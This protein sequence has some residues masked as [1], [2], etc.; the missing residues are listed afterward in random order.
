VAQLYQQGILKLNEVFNHESAMT[1][2][3]FK[4]KVVETEKVGAYDGVVVD[5]AGSAFITG[6][7]TYVV[8]PRDPLKR[9]FSL[10]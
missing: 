4:A 9:G 7:H 1:G 6:M 3:I 5:V 2:T 10:L 8:N